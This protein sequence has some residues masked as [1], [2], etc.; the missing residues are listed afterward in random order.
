[1]EAASHERAV[2]FRVRLE[3]G[4]ARV[5]ACNTYLSVD[6]AIADQCCN[7]TG[8]CV[9]CNRQCVVIVDAGRREASGV[10]QQA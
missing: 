3:V 9:R 1:M 4:E 5:P 6:A 2:M 8:T 10:V 7:G